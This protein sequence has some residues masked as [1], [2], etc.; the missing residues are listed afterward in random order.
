M[1]Y[2]QGVD[3]LQAVFSLRA[4]QRTVWPYAGLGLGRVH[5]LELPLEN[6]AGIEVTKSASSFL[7]GLQWQLLRSLGLTFE[8]HNF[9]LAKEGCDRPGFGEGP[10][11]CHWLPRLG[12]FSSSNDAAHFFGLSHGMSIPFELSLGLN[13]SFGS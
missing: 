12:E 7:F 6:P 2:I 13:W 1:E 11:E 9:W 5:T 3:T 4:N 10:G 8:I